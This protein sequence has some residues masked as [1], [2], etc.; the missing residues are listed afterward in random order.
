MAG[1]SPQ[2]GGVLPAGPVRTPPDGFRTSREGVV[3]NFP[4][5][6]CLSI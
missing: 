6:L 2:M 4:A 1:P 3:A 5:V